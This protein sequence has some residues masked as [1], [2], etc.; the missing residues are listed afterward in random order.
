MRARILALAACVAFNAALADEQKSDAP[1][2]ESLAPYF[3]MAERQ[4]AMQDRGLDFGM[5]Y[6]GEVWGITRGGEK[7]GST[8]NGRL[9]L[10]LD[11]DFGKLNGWTGFNFHGNVFA[12]HGTGPSAGYVGNIF[13]VS[14]VEALPTVRLFELW[15]QQEFLDGAVT[16]RAGQLAADTQ[17]ISSDVAGVFLNGT[18]GWPGIAAANL[19]SGGPAYPL[20]TP[21]VG[22][23]LKVNDQLSFR[24]AVVNG[25][26]A[27]P[28]IGDPQARDRYGLA[29]RVNDGP[30]YN[31]MAIYSWSQATLP[32]TL[33]LGAWYHTG[34]FP[35]QRFG[36]DGFLADGASSGQALEHRNNQ[37]AYVIV[38]QALYRVPGGGERGISVFTRLMGSPADRNLID[39]YVDGGIALKGLAESRPDDTLGFAAA[40]ARI[41]PR[42][43]GF[44]RDVNFFTSSANPIRDHEF[45]FEA[46]YQ[47][48]IV[49]GWTIQ[50]DFQYI[51]RPNGGVV[52]PRDPN[53][54]ALIKNAMVF[55]LRTTLKY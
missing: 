53:G 33:K 11:V 44:D 13:A 30:L 31:G 7:R 42:V 17:Y 40:F 14:N 47:A 55:G 27:G 4:K 23:G 8:G 45:V 19:P 54:T 43:S 32:G 5:T 51:V 3:G 46:T 12:I 38:D 35:D 49:S 6:I 50:P 28:G 2:R 24:F 37:G 25:D 22:L 39:F 48:Q 18:F 34:R 10:S 21:G 52:N 29:F 15:V 16:L 41:S 1:P 20:A 36:I 26:P 9:E